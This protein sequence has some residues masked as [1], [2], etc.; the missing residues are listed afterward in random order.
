MWLIAASI[1]VAV[2]LTAWSSVPE[3]AP[4]GVVYHEPTGAT[5]TTGTAPETLRI[6]LNTATA[7]ELMR[8][9]QL[10]EKTAASILAYRTS[11]NGFDSVEEL[12]LIDGIGE[13]KLETWRPYLCVS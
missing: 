4:I 5:A 9:P 10:G 2:T 7:A 11:H 1:F 8:L 3:F 13:K 6:N 12:L